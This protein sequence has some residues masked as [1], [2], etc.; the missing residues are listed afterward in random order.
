MALIFLIFVEFSQLLETLYPGT[1]Y[2]R[3]FT[4]ASMKS[5]P[6]GKS[7]WV[8]NGIIT[9]ILK[10][11]SLNHHLDSNRNPYLRSHVSLVHYQHRAGTQQ[12][13]GGEG[14]DEA[15]EEE[16]E[17]ESLLI[18]DLDDIMPSAEQKYPFLLINYNIFF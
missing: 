13:N 9:N 15:D 1:W 6:L 14:E 5:L 11:L 3:E 12:T 18:Q 17:E 2:S 10:V 4:K 7:T 8:P 16:E